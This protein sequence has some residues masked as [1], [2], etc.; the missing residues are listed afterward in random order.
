MRNLYALLCFFLLVAP[1]GYAFQRFGS[2]DKPDVENT[3]LEWDFPIARPHAGALLGNGKLGLMIWGKR[4]RLNI[5][6]GRPGFWDHRGGNDFTLRTNYQDVKK[7]LESKDEAGL[8]KAF[9]TPAKAANFPKTP[10]QIGGGTLH[11]DLP[12]GYEWQKAVLYFRKGAIEVIAKDKTGV[13]QRAFIGQDPDSE[14]AWIQFTDG[15]DGG[16][17][18]KQVRLSLTPSYQTPGVKKELEK[19]GVQPPVSW[20]EKGVNGFTQSLPQDAPLSVGYRMKGQV[21]WIGTVLG[22]AGDS[23]SKD[24]VATRF[25]PSGSETRLI[26]SLQNAGLDQLTAARD[27]WWKNYWA[28]VPK[29]QLPDPVLQEI[30]DYGLYKQACA[31]PPQG[32]PCSLQGPFLEDY[33]LPPWSADFH[34]NINEEMIYTPALASNRLSHF[35]PLWNMMKYWLPQ[36]QQNGERFFGRK[37]AL[38]LP[39]AV[40]D[41]CKVVGTFWTGTIDH[42]CT[43]WMAMM[44][45]QYYRYGLDKESL[46]ELGYP[47]MLGAFEGYWA[48]LEEVNDG[49][50]GKRFSLPVS[51]SPEYRG[52]AANAWGRDASFQLAAL[53][54]IV[55]ILPEAAKALGRPVDPRWKD[56]DVRLPPFTLVNQQTFDGDSWMNTNFKQPH[57]GLWEGQELE[58][59]HRHHSHLG[60][61]Y[62]FCTVDPNDTAYRKIVQASVKYWV[63]KGTGMWSGWCVPWASVIHSRCGETESAVSLLHWWNDNFV[64]EG[65]GTLHNANKP[66]ISLLAN[67]VY[68]K[69]PAGT[70]NN[71]VMQLDAGFG[72]LTAVFELLIQNRADGIYVLP[73]LHQN[74]KTLHFDGI[75]TEGA[76]LVSAQVKG[77]KV[78]EVKVTSKKGG[79]LVLYPGLGDRF[80]VNSAEHAG[81]KLE[82]DC[83]AGEE[84]IL[85]SME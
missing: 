29:I 16:N 83:A 51:V 72:A 13:E 15:A 34:F 73:N 85:R 33:Q 40:D 75:L 12:E 69:L 42:A 60:S 32:L 70:P 64:N 78:V 28:E 84:L 6:I 18:G 71:E 49:K 48:M 45:W 82:K 57:I 5:T 55:R 20:K 25:K 80:L 21:V 47:L 41:R 10:F 11:I 24:T 66:G 14:L 59:S 31:S 19:M 23:G 22:D 67:P 50:G 43:A 36:L 17:F 79:R 56:V 39:H 52:D 81:A 68:D 63:F 30:V 3:T 37:G 61:I 65:R 27:L 46:E 74:W 7:L 1:S 8:R 35:A 53:H 9:E 62:P 58:D 26:A 2:T 77:G 38:M 44:A 76:F 4:N 54:K